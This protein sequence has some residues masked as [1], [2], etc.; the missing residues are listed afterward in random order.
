MSSSHDNTQQIVITGQGLLT[1]LG[2]SAGTIVDNWM[3][4]RSAAAPITALDATNLPVQ[5]ACEITD[6][7][8]RKEV[9][10]RKLLRLLMRGEDYGMVAAAAALKDAG[11]GADDYDPTR[12]GI[13]VGIRKEGFRN[14]NFDD[15]IN[16]ATDDEGHISRQMFIEEGMRRVPPQTIVEGLANAGIYHIAHEHRLQGFNL[17]WLA[18]GSGGFQAIGEAMWALRRDEAD[19]VLAGAFDSWL[20]WNSVSFTHFIGIASPSTDAPETV[21]R[22]F[23]VSRTGSVIGEGAALF[24]MESR[25]RAE[26]R[27][28]TILGEVRGMGVATGV[29]SG[30]SQACAA[31]LAASICRSLEVARLAPQDIDMIH[32]HGDATIAGDR[33]EV[34]GLCEAFGQLAETIPATTIKSATGFMANASASV[35]VAAALEVLRRGEIPPVANLTAPDPD[36]RLRFV[37]E[38]LTGMPLRH[39]LLIERSWP[40]QYVTLIVSRA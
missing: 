35:E 18:V 13:A 8:P 21:H 40:S 25:E 39:A 14:S 9:R 16:I 24:V 27:G 23:D 28:A 20:N 15:A 34:Q 38:P 31:A 29:P 22:P 37:Q 26:A 3:A 1:P 30:D 7:E 2:R 6:F 4:G 33:A 12:A 5:I 36:F 11:L 32:L 10:N 19:L 17:N